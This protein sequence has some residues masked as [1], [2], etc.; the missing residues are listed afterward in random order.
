MSLFNQEYATKMMI[1]NERKEAEAKGIAKGIA[2]EKAK[3]ALKLLSKNFL[4]I[5]EIAEITDLPAKKI[6]ELADSLKFPGS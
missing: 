5:S 1:I 6:K 2:K 3:T 4:S